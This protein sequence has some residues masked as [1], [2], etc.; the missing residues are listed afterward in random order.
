MH[1][2][3]FVVPYAI[4]TQRHLKMLGG[5]PRPLTPFVHDKA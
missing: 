3:H 1:P 2:E 4:V 5:I